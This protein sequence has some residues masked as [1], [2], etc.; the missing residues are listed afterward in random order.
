MGQ[1]PGPGSHIS[2]K[3]PGDAT[4]PVLDH[5]TGKEGLEG[6]GTQKRPPILHQSTRPDFDSENTP[7]ARP[8]PGSAKHGFLL[9]PLRTHAL[10]TP[11]H[12]AEVIVEVMVP[13][14]AP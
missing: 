9:P 13:L 6:P 4:L 3:L 8:A 7:P 5:T 14:L 12:E 1:E 11:S 10:P 2:T